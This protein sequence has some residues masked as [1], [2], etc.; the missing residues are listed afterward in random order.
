MNALRRRTVPLLVL[1]ALVL[2]DGASADAP[3]YGPAG[4]PRAVPLSLDHAY[5]GGSPAP[6]FWALIPYY[7]AQ[8]NDAACSAASV[9]MVVNAAVCAGRALGNGDRIVT[10]ASLLDRVEIE[11]WKELASPVGHAGLHGLTLAQLGAV[12]EA[13]LRDFGAEK[14]AVRSAEADGTEEGLARFRAALAENEHSAH[15]A[16]LLHFVQDEV[17]AAPG[18]PFAHISP[19]GAY[20]AGRRRVL[21]LDV[22]REWYEPYWVADDVLFRAMSR[23]TLAFGAGGFLWVGFGQ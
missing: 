18:G 20:D 10:R 13:A 7:V 1:L 21:V 4:A 15:D 22:D 8:M 14:P 19:V 5:L 3:K 17:T 16:M 9:S 23:R 11:H 2:R 6:D 12:T